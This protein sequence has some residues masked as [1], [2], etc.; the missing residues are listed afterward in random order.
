MVHTRLRLVVIL[1]FTRAWDGAEDYDDRQHAL[2][3]A[4]YS[5]WLTHLRSHLGTRGWQV[6]QANFTVGSRGSILHSR[7]E[8]LLDYFRVPSSARPRIYSLIHHQALS[9]LH[10]V[11][12]AAKSAR[13]KQLS[14]PT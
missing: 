5:A 14:P 10:D 8:A 1:E 7:W 11:F 2:K 13:L 12:Q 3:G 4:R 9:S 6:H